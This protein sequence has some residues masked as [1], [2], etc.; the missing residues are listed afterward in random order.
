M[1]RDCLFD[2]WLRKGSVFRVSVGC[3]VIAVATAA[4]GCSPAYHS[5]SLE[6]WDAASSSAIT[7]VNLQSSIAARKPLS[8]DFA[9]IRSGRTDPQ[10]TRVGV[11]YGSER[12]NQVLEIP[13][14]V[15]ESPDA[16]ALVSR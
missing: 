7:T 1:K 6:D 9:I 13:Q 4:V 12:S 8:G 14:A 3:A 11:I 10:W 15:S 2:K 16:A 5:E